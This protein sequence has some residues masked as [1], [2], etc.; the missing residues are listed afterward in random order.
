VANSPHDVDEAALLPLDESA[1]PLVRLEM[2][3]ALPYFALLIQNTDYV[4]GARVLQCIGWMPASGFAFEKGRHELCDLAF[5]FGMTGQQL[6]EH[7]ADRLH[8]KEAGQTL[9]FESYK[10]RFDTG[11]LRISYDGI[12]LTA[13]LHF[14][15]SMLFGTMWNDSSALNWIELKREGGTLTAVGES[16]RFPYRQHWTVEAR[17]EGIV[18]RILLEVKE[19][20][21][22]DEYHAS[23][24]LRSEY[25]HWQTEHESGE[26]PAFEE[27]VTD[28]R[29]AN[30][31]YAPGK[32]VSAFS[33]SFPTISICATSDD[34]VFQMTA[35]NTGFHE[36][37][38]VLQ[39]LHSPG[40]M[41]HL[42]AGTYTYFEGIIS[43]DPAKKT[44]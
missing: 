44:S 21:D 13:F 29:H 28:W 15:T 7:I 16:R 17:R 26:F 42:D 10:V 8:A 24:L 6:I 11:M 22:L 4:T 9:E 25:S 33:E 34:V 38:R 43:A 5:D 40:T 30:R 14:Y 2:R 1:A 20:M 35:I 3:E 41:M 32:Q 27:G 18:V 36:R 31:K 12:E 39:A 23:I 19:P 37:A